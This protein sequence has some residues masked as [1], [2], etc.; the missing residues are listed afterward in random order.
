MWLDGK[1][2]EFVN[3]SSKLLRFQCFCEAVGNIVV[4]VDFE[5][6]NVSGF[7]EFFDIV[8]LNIHLFRLGCRMWHGCCCDCTC[9][10]NV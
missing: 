1:E 7:D 9:I 10:V 6:L 5:G 4:C 8:V 2:V 3:A